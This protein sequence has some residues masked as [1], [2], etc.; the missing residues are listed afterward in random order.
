MDFFFDT[1]GHYFGQNAGFETEFNWTIAIKECI[2]CIFVASQR[3]TEDALCSLGDSFKITHLR[4]ACKLVL[5][6]PYQIYSAIS[7]PSPPIVLPLLQ[8]LSDIFDSFAV[9]HS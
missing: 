1:L 7:R 9:S 6:Q 8:H 2:Q 5:F 4:A 3:T